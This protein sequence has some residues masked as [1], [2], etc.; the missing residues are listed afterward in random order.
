MARLAQEAPQQSRGPDF[1]GI[2][3]EQ[4]QE[5]A[6][7]GIEPPSADMM[8]RRRVPDKVLELTQEDLDDTVTV[9]CFVDSQPWTHER[10]LAQGEQTIIPRKVALEMEQRRQVAIVRDA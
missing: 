9:V 8:I 1:N 4:A 2:S 3:Y 6:Q 10:P 7:R 5:L